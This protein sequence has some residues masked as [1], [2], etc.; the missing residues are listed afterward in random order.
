MA[1]ITLR[2]KHYEWDASSQDFVADDGESY[3]QGLQRIADIESGQPTEITQG[4]P[5]ATQ[6]V[7]TPTSDQS[8]AETDRLNR[9]EGG[10]SGAGNISPGSDIPDDTEDQSQAE[11]DRLNRQ[12]RGESGLGNISPGSDIPDDKTG[13]KAGDKAGDKGMTDAQKKM[14]GAMGGIGLLLL[15]KMLGGGL[16]SSKRQ[17]T[18]FQGNI[19]LGARAERRALQGTNDP[20][21][22]PGSGGIGYFTP[23]AI[24]TPE[25]AGEIDAAMDQLETQGNA[26]NAAVNA[27]L[28]KFAAGGI[29]DL[30]SAPR[31]LRGETDGMADEVPANIEGKQEARLAHGEFVI[32]ADVVSHLGNGNSDAG[33]KKLH[34]MMEQVRTARTGTPE[35]GKEIDPNKFIST[36]TGGINNLVAPA[37]PAPPQVLRFDEGGTVPQDNPL[38]TYFGPYV[39]NMM[40]QANALAESPYQRYTGPLTAGTSPLQDQAYLGASSLNMPAGM[41]TT[42]Y[43]PASFTGNGISQQYMNPYITNALNPTIAEMRR[44]S[45]ITQMQNNAKM[46]AAGAYGGSRQA[47]MNTETQRNLLDKIGQTVGQGYATAFDKAQNQFNTEQQQRS[48]AQSDI[49]RYG[50]D[51]LNMRNN[52]GTQQRDIIQ[53]G[54]T[55]D[56]AAFEEER[57]NP[58]KMLQFKQAMLSGMPIT[59]T[60]TGQY[61]PSLLKQLS[62]AG[63]GGMTLAEILNSGLLGTG[64]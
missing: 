1:G 60:Q 42:G 53:E 58:Y 35:Q 3:E 22:M 30:T 2:G 7:T 44:Q 41:G 45:D 4:G 29:T 37:T 8:Q 49:N 40:T 38:N 20:N 12:N 16:L 27:T 55:A 61:S 28:P 34:E 56:K 17:A 23:T 15:D 11:T 26:A 32:P 33:A 48:S 54:L 25:S 24:S 31:Y 21:R 59:N 18:G 57:A 51:L 50:I 14:L 63:L 47:L 6:P 19:N 39:N 9:Q 46:V 43:N 62:E 64:G 36:A 13:D 52:L 5:D 10:Q